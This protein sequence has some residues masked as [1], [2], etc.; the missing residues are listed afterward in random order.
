MTQMGIVLK[1]VYWLDVLCSWFSISKQKIMKKYIIIIT[2]FLACL[3]NHLLAQKTP[4]NAVSKSQRFSDRY[5]LTELY[6]SLNGSSWKNN[7]N[8]LTSKP[9]NTWYGVE[10]F[11]DG[12]VKAL[13]LSNNNLNG[14][15]PNVIEQLNLETFI[16]TGN[17]VKTPETLTGFLSNVELGTEKKSK[18]STDIKTLLAGIKNVVTNLQDCEPN[19]ALVVD[20][21]GSIQGSEITQIKA[22]LTSFVNDVT[23]IGMTLSLIG[24]SPQDENERSDHILETLLT[25][26]NQSLFLDWVEDYR[27]RG[28]SISSDYW[29]SGLQVVLEDLTQK[30]DVVIVV[31]DGSQ[32]HDVQVVKDR[33]TA[34]ENQNS[35]F[36]VFG[37]T[38]GNYLNASSYPTLQPLVNS[39]EVLLDRTPILLSSSTNILTSDVSP[40]DNFTSLSVSLAS[41]PETLEEA[42]VGCDQDTPPNDDCDDCYSFRPGGIDFNGDVK[43][44]MISAWVKEVHQEQVI[45]YGDSGV[46]VNFF[47]EN[48]LLIHSS[49]FSPIGKVIEG[50]QRIMG[51]FIVPM[52]TASMEIE[53][54]SLDT[55]IDCY[56]D[57]LRV[58]P[59]NGNLKSFVYDPVTLRLMAELDENNY[60]T[61]YE[62]DKE[63]GLVRV[64]KETEKGVLTIQENR[65]KTVLKP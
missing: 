5:I 28:M 26:S 29:A 22:G 37:I 55:N 58:H 39:L 1:R 50:W 33:I 3:S 61:F 57:D 36:F 32:S 17:R 9:L 12:R 40:N 13:R 24:M 19:V 7:T 21:S 51:E 30:P 62:Y 10:T 31:T 52:A 46:K 2:V 25:S 14:L 49:T 53:L 47:D 11:K 65:S 38:N 15:L 64:K 41:L 23:D 27:Q 54:L 6:K 35:V 16:F 18:S 63:G 44:Y 42:Q 34:I 60:A 8:W 56:F 4:Q 43:K 20:E 59:Y 45:G 48:D